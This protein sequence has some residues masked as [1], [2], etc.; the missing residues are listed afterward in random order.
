METNDQKLFFDIFN[1]YSPSEKEKNILNNA[2]N[3]KISTDREQRLIEIELCF[4]NL[5][6]KD[7]LRATEQKLC[8]IYNLN[9]MFFKPKYKKELFCDEYFAQ[10]LAEAKRRTAD[11]CFLMDS[12]IKS[13]NEKIKISLAHGGKNYLEEAANFV[14]LLKKIIASEFDFYADIE[15]GG[16][17]ALYKNDEQDIANTAKNLKKIEDEVK[18]G[19]K[20]QK[21]AKK[22]EKETKKRE[23]QREKAEK[24]YSKTNKLID[25]ESLTNS[26]NPEA[27]NNAVFYDEQTGILV[28]GFLKT[29][30]LQKEH[31]FSISETNEEEISPDDLIPI[32]AIDGDMVINS[33]MGESSGFVVTCGKIFSIES[34]DLRR[35]DKKSAVIKITDYCSSIIVKLIDTEKNVSRLLKNIEEGDYAI[36][37]GEAKFDDYDEEIVV[38]LDSLTKIK[39]FKNIDNAPKKRVE[40]HLHTAMSNMDATIKPEEIIKHAH[41]TGHRAVALTDHGNVQAFPEAMLAKEKLKLKEGEEFKIIYGIEGYLSDDSGSSV[42]GKV[43]ARFNEDIFIIFDIETTGLSPSNCGITEIGAVKIKEGEI[44]EEFNTFVNPGMPIPQKTIELNG[45]TDE[46][47]KDAPKIREALKSFFD[48]AGNNMLVAHNAAFDIGFIK[49]YASVCQYDFT[50]PYLDTLAM[51]RNINKDLKRHNLEALVEFYKIEQF[52]HHR[53]C[54]DARVLA[55]IFMNMAEQMKSFGVLTVFEMNEM[56]SSAERQTYHIILLVQN[57]TGLKNLYK[58]VSESYLD[59]FYKRAKIPKSVLENYREGIIVGSACESGELFSA[60]T[61]G[62]KDEELKKIAEFYDYLEIQPIGNNMFLVNNGTVPNEEALKKLNM[63]IIEIGE[64]TNKPVVA[65]GDVHFLEKHDEI[66]RKILLAGMKFSDSDRH[67]PLY[68]RTTDEMLGEFSYLQKEKAYEIVVENTNKIA[69]MI[70][71]VRPIPKGSYTPKMEGAEERLKEICHKKAVEIYKDPLPEIVKKRL[72]R[73]LEAI[74]ENGFAVLYVIAMD[75]VSNSEKKGYLVASRGSVGSSFVATLAGI[76]EVNPLPPHYWCKNKNCAYSEFITDGSF[77][78]GYD[79]PEKNCPECEE[80]L[81]REGQDIPFETFLGFHGEKAPDIDLNFSGDVQAAAHKYTEELFGREN[82]FRAGTIGAL[83]DKTAYGFVMKY[84]EDKK[85]SLNKAHTDWLVS[86]CVGVK[87]TTG[88]HPGGIIVVPREYEIYDFTPVQHPADDVKSNVVTTHF[89]FEFL[90]ETILKL[91]LLGHDVP[92]KYKILKEM[93]GIDV[94]DLPTNDK[95]VM[96]LFVSTNSIGVNP[97]DIYNELGTFGIPEMGTKFVRQMIMETKPETFADLLQISGLSHGT[98][99]WVGNARELIK[100]GVCKLPEVIGIRDNIM[101]Y[102]IQK[103]LKPDIAFLITESVRKGKGLTPEWEQIMREN[104]VPDWYMDSCKKIKYMFPKA[105]ASAYIIAA[106]R[107]GWFKVYKPLEFYASYFT[108]QPEGLDAELVLSGTENIRN[109][110]EEIEKKGVEAKQKENE[111][112][113]AMQ[114]VLEM[115]ARGLKFL[116]VDIYKSAAFEYKIEQGKIRLPFSSLNGV[117]ETAAENITEV[118]NNS[119]GNIFSIEE[120]W[121][122]AKLTKTAV[123]ILKRNNVFGDIPETDQISLF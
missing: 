69:D 67:I 79:L 76:T 39:E 97:K 2:R 9:G 50:N 43:N 30:F 122:K 98:D 71:D 89:P 12:E 88:Q 55:M 94:R 7:F 86:K 13:E 84:L 19:L 99:V 14:D 61:E 32:S 49:K 48:F 47:V 5:V 23:L 44:I 16:I 57:K 118:R 51:S 65:T 45:I 17:V 102:L 100:N 59:Y 120:I 40:L 27:E 60:V 121:K 25:S 85:T 21:T 52:R 90:Q 53:A 24:I 29:N 108:V 107:L 56:A 63:K 58:I 28:S 64:K 104:D 66:S 22:I 41:K 92:T 80:K 77:G 1:K 111:V 31:I 74:I 114:L 20:E 96:E 11:V 91:D 6:E 109:H 110:I 18:N 73:E 46:T 38:N 116:P 112:M 10:I 81:S 3:I 26:A 113:T 62:K 34:K 78:S 82:V 106:M 105:H 35:S 83:A 119:N 72:E 95:N 68:Y 4:E 54:D 70:E 33:E 42:V 93:T 117:G 115:Y 103:N 123:E 8:E 101:L 37:S 87:R 15:L 36:I 75:L